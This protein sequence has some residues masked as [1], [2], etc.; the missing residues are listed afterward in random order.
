MSHQ[1][2]ALLSKLFVAITAPT[3]TSAE[4][5]VMTRPMAILMGVLGSYFLLRM[6]PQNP[7]I[8]GVSN[9]TQKGLM[10]WYS[11]VE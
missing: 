4:S 8:T 6:K 7:T 2:L 1:L 9:T 5:A 11:W 10:L 3:I